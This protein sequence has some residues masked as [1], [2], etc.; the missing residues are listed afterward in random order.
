MLQYYIEKYAAD[1]CEPVM[2]YTKEE[3]SFEG[4]EP[5][6]DLNGDG[7]VDSVFVLPLLAWCSYPGEEEEI[8]GDSYYFT[9]TTLPRLHTN[10][11]CCHPYNIFPVGDIDE[12]GIK[13]IGEYYSSCASR[14]K[15]L[16]L[17]TLKGN[18]W[19]YI[20]HVLYDLFYV[21]TSLKYSQFVRKVS[22]GKVEML[23][24][25]DMTENPKDVGKKVWKRFTF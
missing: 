4:F 9:D 2:H 5:L 17:H 10:S 24:I 8:D 13:E 18:R 7:N 14:Y 6:G 21:V 11:S 12:D 23:E 20:G 16:Q 3:F 1:S 22:K 25:T 15:L 19:Q